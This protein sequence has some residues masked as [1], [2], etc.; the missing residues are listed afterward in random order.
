MNF[1]KQPSFITVA[2]S[3]AYG[4]N[5]ETSDLDIVG[6]VAPPKEVLNNIFQGFDEW[7]N[8]LEVNNQF[9]HLVN[10]LNPKIESKIYSLKKFFQLAAECNPNIIE[11][12]W[13]DE[14]DILFADKIGEKVLQNRELFLSSQAKFRFLGYSFAQ[15]QKIE[16]HR[17]W[18]LKGEIAEPKRVDYGL[19]E[20]E[21]KFMGEIYR[22]V[23]NQVEEWNFHDYPLDTEQR[24]ELK[25]KIWGLVYQIN[26]TQI[27]WG[28]WPE[29]HE[30]AALGKLFEDLELTAEVQEY[31]NKEIQ[32]K[33]AHKEYS[34]WLNWKKNR[35]VERKGMETKSGYD[36]KMAMHLIRLGR[37]GLEILQTGKIQ[38]KRP[39]RDELLEIKRGDWPYEKVM[40]EFKKLDSLMEIAYKETKL[41]RTVDKDKINELYWSLI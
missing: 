17:K 37:V 39:D 22:V 33:N 28:N 23:K 32:Y 30:G 24:Q 29:I 34:S 19:R 9:A 7:S 2:G 25:E 11:L 38:T 13:V 35:N 10:P 26:N 41:P 27:N 18:L 12:L 21:P 4:L 8:K 14:A 15:F 1:F 36:L 3:R 6:F 5:T 20:Q 40:E 31:I 16:R